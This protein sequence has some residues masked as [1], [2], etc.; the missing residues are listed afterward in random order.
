MTTAEAL[1]IVLKMAHDSYSKEF[2]PT[3]AEQSAIDKVDELLTSFGDY[4]E[5]YTEEPEA[6]DSGSNTPNFDWEES[7]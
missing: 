7:E 6:E 2:G 3:E 5:G 4:E 1:K